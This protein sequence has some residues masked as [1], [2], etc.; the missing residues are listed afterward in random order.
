MCWYLYELDVVATEILSLDQWQQD[1][2][3]ILFIFL[4]TESH[5]TAHAV[6]KLVVIQLQSLNDK[7]TDVYY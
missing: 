4:E 7:I 1:K 6:L 5:Y 2:R 3:S